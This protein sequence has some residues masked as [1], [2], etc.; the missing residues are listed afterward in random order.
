MDLFKRVV[1]NITFPTLTE[2]EERQDRDNNNDILSIE[3]SN[4]DEIK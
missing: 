2:R 1:Q 3:S 4:K